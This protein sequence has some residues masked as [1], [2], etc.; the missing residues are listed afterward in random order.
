MLTAIS[1]LIGLLG[2]FLPSLVSYLT[3]KDELKHDLELAKLNITAQENAAKNQLSIENIKADAVEAT[4]LRNFDN[5]TDGG[6]FVNALRASVRPVITYIFFLLFLAVK[7]SAAYVMISTGD[8]IPQMLASVW[9]V[10]TAAL[11]ATVVAFWFGAR[12]LEKREDSIAASR[13]Y[14]VLNTPTMKITPKK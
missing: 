7:T 12:A 6:K 1:A 5:G 3:K 14:K 13:Q 8:S 4:A 9:D 11:F 10:E 2:S